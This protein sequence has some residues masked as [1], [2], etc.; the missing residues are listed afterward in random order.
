MDAPLLEVKNLTIRFR[1]QRG[2]LNA[3]ENVSFS[4]RE[5]ETFGIVGETGCGKT[6]TSLSILRLIPC[7][8]GEIAGGEILFHG[9]DLLKKSEREME[10]IRGRKISMIFQEPM[11]SL[12]PSLTIGEQIGEC[13]R[14]HMGHSAKVAR[15]FAE[16]TLHLVQLP[17]PRT[18][19]RRYPHEL[20]GGMRQRVMIAMALA[21]Q[22]ELLIADEPT[23]AL[24]V[25]IQAQ[26]LELL[27]ELQMKMKM[28][29]IFISH[30]LGV[31]ARLCDH[32]GV[33]YAGSLVEL[34]DKK[35]LFAHPLHP[36]TQALLGAIPRPELRDQALRAIPGSVCNLF[37]P[38]PGCKFHPRCPKAKEICKSDMPRLEAK[39]SESLAACYFPGG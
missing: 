9:E 25:T 26:I 38:P 31:V 14:V 33:M 8:P 29:L 7:P 15:Q 3:V 21:C 1:L 2:V 19:A 36:Y 17:S 27:R 11:T 20:S 35:N 13:Y 32:I 23:T 34:S 16:H 37:E 6:V 5:G 22:P 4:L 30:N 39:T 28:A 10:K 12:N 24:D 18:L